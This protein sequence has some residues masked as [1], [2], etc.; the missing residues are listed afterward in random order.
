[1]D[2][3]EAESL[4]E[5]DLTEHSWAFLLD[6][7]C[8]SPPWG[9]CRFSKVSTPCSWIWKMSKFESEN[10]KSEGRKFPAQSRCLGSCGGLRD[11]HQTYQSLTQAKAEAE[12]PGSVFD[13]N[14]FP[15]CQLKQNRFSLF[16]PV[17]PPSDTAYCADCLGEFSS[18]R[19]VRLAGCASRLLLW[20]WA[21]RKVIARWLLERLRWPG[22]IVLG[23]EETTFPSFSQP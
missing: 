4:R 19:A 8:V 15:S 22:C 23:E 17:F 1:M 16:Q 18:G 9:T 3:Q 6:R 12:L 10:D 14:G 7:F 11:C 20:W 2:T 13:S 21:A 5:G